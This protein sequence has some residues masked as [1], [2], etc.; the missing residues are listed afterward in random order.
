MQSLTVEF[1]FPLGN[2]E[3]GVTPGV[4][5]LSDLF[6]GREQGD[7]EFCILTDLYRTFGAVV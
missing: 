4:E 5:R 3:P 1:D 2:L 6:S 7:E